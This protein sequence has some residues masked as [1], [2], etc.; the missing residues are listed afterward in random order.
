MSQREQREQ[1]PLPGAPDVSHLVTEDG[2]PVDSFLAEK[3]MRLLTA[4]LDCWTAPRGRRFIAAANVGLFAVAKNPAIVPD[5]FVSFDVDPPAASGP[6]KLSSYF[7]WELGKPP[8]IV[9]EIVSETL[10]GE[11]STKLRDYERMRITNYVVFDPLRRLGS[12]E[13]V[14]FSLHSGAYVQRNDTR[15]VAEG[16]ALVRWDGTFEGM[17]TNWLRWTDLDGN[18]LPTPR[19]SEERARREA[20]RADR[21]AQRAAAAEARAESSATRAEALA[22]RLRALGVDPDA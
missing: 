22:A 18:L 13:V 5:V 4:P 7:F 20:E 12:E 11:L 15:F 3:Q 2:A 1:A 8:D 17:H 14:A 9:I 19:E 21:E 16:L 10:G 6:E